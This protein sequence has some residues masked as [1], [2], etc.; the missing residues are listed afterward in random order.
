ML[1]D[2]YIG[3]TVLRSFLLI[4]AGLTAL[5]SLLVF[6]EQL[7]LVGQGQYRATDALTYTLLTAPDRLLQLAPVCMLLAALLGLGQL[8]RGSEL[9]ALRSFGVSEAR[10]IAAVLKLCGPVVLGLFLM[11]QFII[12]PAQLAAQRS[13]AAALGDALPGLSDG[14]FWA[15]KDHEFLNVRSFTGGDMLHGVSL[16]AFDPSGGLRLYIQAARAQI[17]PGGSWTLSG[18]IRKTLHNGQI[19]TDRPASLDWT[20]F[21]DH[22]AAAF[23]GDAAPDHA[24]GCLVF[25]C[26]RIATPASAVAALRADVLE[27]GGDPDLAGRHGADRRP[28]RVRGNADGQRRPADPYRCIAG[29]CLRADLDHHRLSRAVA[30]VESGN[31][32]AGALDMSAGLRR[33]AA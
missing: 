7:G 19:Q 10:I 22:P 16:Y 2:R 31:L 12:P 18:V 33:L 15:E 21:P 25:L 28:I 30:A 4:A 8:A 5:F 11:A 1:L 20:P 13:Q 26:A 24:A 23:A 17:A 9:T 14:G 27:H 32:R 29:H 3:W 6:V